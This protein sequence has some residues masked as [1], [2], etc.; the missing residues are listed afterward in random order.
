[1]KRNKIKHAWVPTIDRCRFQCCWF[2]DPKTGKTVVIRIK[3]PLYTGEAPAVVYKDDNRLGA[4]KSK[5]Y[6]NYLKSE[7]MLDK[8]VAERRR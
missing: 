1:M 6:G 8:K 4:R 3:A 2:T 5:L 7:L